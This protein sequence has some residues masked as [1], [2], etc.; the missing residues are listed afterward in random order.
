MY[1]LKFQLEVCG[2]SFNKYVSVVDECSSCNS[3]SLKREV[4]MA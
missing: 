3:Q 2:S 4:Q 1:T